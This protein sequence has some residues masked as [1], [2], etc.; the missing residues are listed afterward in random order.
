MRPCSSSSHYLQLISRAKPRI[1]P[2]EHEV[3]RPHEQRD[4]LFLKLQH[5][6]ILYWPKM[7]EKFVER[8]IQGWRRKSQLGRDSC[9]WVILNILAAMSS[10]T[11]K[12]WGWCFGTWGKIFYQEIGVNFKIVVWEYCRQN[13][14]STK[15][16]PLNIH[17]LFRTV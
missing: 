13:K 1:S 3:L 9:L 8:G 2:R 11:L 4:G 15:G 10:T 5:F 14:N 12:L 6:F 7:K 17:V 16:R